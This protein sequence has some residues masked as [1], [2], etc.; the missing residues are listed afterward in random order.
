MYQNLRYSVDTLCQRMH[1]Y[2][3]YIN[4]TFVTDRVMV[5]VGIFQKSLRCFQVAQYTQA[6]LG[7]T[8]AFSSLE[9]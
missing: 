4:F 1:I 8:L 3:L 5:M 7:T 2:L 6:D 9:D